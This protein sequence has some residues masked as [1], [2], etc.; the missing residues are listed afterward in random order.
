MWMSA[1][2]VDQERE[3]RKKIALPKLKHEKQLEMHRKMHQGERLMAVVK[4]E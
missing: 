2:L 3:K 4:V 1:I